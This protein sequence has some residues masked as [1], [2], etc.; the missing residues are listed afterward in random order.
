MTCSTS[1]CYQQETSLVLYCVLGDVLLD[2]ST[3]NAFL[4]H[5]NYSTTSHVTQESKCTREISVCVHC[6]YV[7]AIFVG[8]ILVTDVPSKVVWGARDHTTHTHWSRWYW[9]L[10][11]SICPSV[12]RHCP[13]HADRPGYLCVAFDY[14]LGTC[15]DTMP[16]PPACSIS[17]SGHPSKI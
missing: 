1:R 14:R 10:Q 8:G 13:R 2:S 4:G 17:V 5:P 6:F 12:R 9:L 11:R 15:E 3:V 7:Y 16:W